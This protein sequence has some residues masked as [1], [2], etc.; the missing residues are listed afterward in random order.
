MPDFSRPPCWPEGQ[1]CPNA[2]ARAQHDRI[3]HNRHELHGPWAGWRFAGRDLVSPDGDRISARRLRGLLFAESR[4][5]RCAQLQAN[6]ARVRPMVL[7]PREPF[8]G[9]A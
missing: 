7:P 1:A 9:C 3:V 4:R 2:C 5:R 6:A 8:D